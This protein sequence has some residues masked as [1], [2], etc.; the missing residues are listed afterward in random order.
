[1]STASCPL[2]LQTSP[3]LLTPE[4]DL[5]HARRRPRYSETKLW[6][7]SHI[8]C[9][10]TFYQRG[11]LLRHQRLKS[12]VDERKNYD[13]SCQ[14]WPVMKRQLLYGVLAGIHPV[15]T[16][17]IVPQMCLIYWGGGHFVR[18]CKT[19]ASLRVF[20]WTILRVVMETLTGIVFAYTCY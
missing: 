9:G 14:I 18:I 13:L 6:R 12:H 2:A 4:Y 8:G 15:R 16:Q 1:M 3:R 7:C 20:V 11:H 10:K 5:F 19:N 17:G